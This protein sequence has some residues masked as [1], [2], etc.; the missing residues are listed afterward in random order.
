MKK[1]ILI[2][3]DTPTHPTIAGNRQ[4]ILS[5][6]DLLDKSGF[7]VFFLYIKSP[8]R[9]REVVEEM[10]DY[11]KDNLFVFRVSLFQFFLQCAI[12]VI[13]RVLT[14]NYCSL[15]IFCPWFVSRKVRKLVK[16]YDI[17][18]VIVNYIWLTKIFKQINIKNRI[19]YTHDVFSYKYLKGNSRW[20]SYSPNVESIALQRCNKILAIQENEAI[21]FQYLSPLSKVYTVF[22]P[23]KFHSQTVLHNN[24]NLLFFSGDNTYNQNGIKKFVNDIFPFIKSKYP[25]IK[26]K[27]GGGICSHLKEYNDESI[28]LMGKYDDPA[29]FYALGNIV[30]NPVYEGTGLKIKTFEAISYG[31]VVLAHPHSFEGVYDPVNIPMYKCAT[32]EDYLRCLDEIICSGH[33][34]FE[35]VQRKCSAYIE[36]MTNSILAQYKQALS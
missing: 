8:L 15:D 22:S 5:Y 9:D 11:W 27:I 31:K 14:K 24:F 17:E 3:S 36:R 29:D 23:F 2:I 35:D 6:C 7:N 30:I 13:A 1:N 21:Y 34:L 28:C 19:I 32:V 4:A 16:Q 10:K 33:F 12:L 20:F 26:V 18:S 25:Y